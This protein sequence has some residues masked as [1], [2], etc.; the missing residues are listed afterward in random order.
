MG[1]KDGRRSRRVAVI[2]TL[3]LLVLLPLIFF[4]SGT[5]WIS[6]SAAAAPPEVFSIFFTCDTQGHIEPCG[7]A[8]G[9]AGGI[10]RRQTFLAANLPSDYLLVDAGDVTAGRRE[11]EILE[12]EYILKGYALMGYHAVNLGQREIALDL[13]EL[14]R[15]RQH[16]AQ[17]VSANVVD[18]AA[19]PVVDPFVIV[20]LS[21][22]Y[23]CGIIGIVDDQLEP[24][25]IGA[26]LHLISPAEALARYLPQLKEEADF[27]VLLAFT[28]E[29]EMHALARQFFE[30]DVIVGGKVRQTVAEPIRENRSAIVFNTDK[31][32]N[33]GRLDIRHPKDQAREFAGQ[34]HV[35]EESMEKDSAIVALVEE[36]KAQLKARDFR[37]VKDDEEGLSMISTVRSKTANRYT[38]PEDCRECHAKA[39]EIW[40][41]SKHAHAFETLEQKGHQYNPRC[42][43]CHTVGYMASDGYVSQSLTPTL[44]NVS[45]DACH[46]RGNYH[47][48]EKSGEDVPGA[49]VLMKTPDCLVCHDEENSPNFEPVSYWEKIAHGT[50]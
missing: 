37:P 50:E 36:Y 35:L 6:S 10:S 16:Y 15:I 31:G 26:G 49:R 19:R 43:K 13:E 17:L 42:L 23:R 46:G 32:K 40:A 34:V 27:I 28:T 11:W 41:H 33:L 22:G 1:A 29:A 4:V 9:M 3:A 7:C 48:K 5:H 45:C 18:G 30:L 44:Q 21:N 47:V 20:E 12:M 8:S 39:F 14:L 38:G 24:D 2:A 25:E